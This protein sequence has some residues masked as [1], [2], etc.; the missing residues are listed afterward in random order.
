MPYNIDP[1]CHITRARRRRA[2][3]LQAVAVTAAE[4]DN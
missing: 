2:L 4:G 3:R 1:K